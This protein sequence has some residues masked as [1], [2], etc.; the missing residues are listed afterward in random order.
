MLLAV[1]VAAVHIGPRLPP[2][3]AFLSSRGLL[4]AGRITLVVVAVVSV[5]SFVTAV[6]TILHAS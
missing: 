1:G 5:P 4:I 3:R 6:D 2:G